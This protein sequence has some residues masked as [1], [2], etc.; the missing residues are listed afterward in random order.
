MKISRRIPEAAEVVFEHAN[1][2]SR[3]SKNYRSLRLYRDRKWKNQVQKYILSYY[4]VVQGYAEE[5]GWYRDVYIMEEDECFN[6]IQKY[7]NSAPGNIG[8][9]ENKIKLHE[10]MIGYPSKYGALSGLDGRGRLKLL[11]PMR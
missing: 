10:A 6:I 7:Q 3:T 2:V 5:R 1:N 8:H 9:P 4:M 11:K